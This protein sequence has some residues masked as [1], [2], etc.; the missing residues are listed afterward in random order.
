MGRP[1]MEMGFLP[2]LHRPTCI[3]NNAST[4]LPYLNELNLSFPSLALVL[5]LLT[6]EVELFE[7]L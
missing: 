6:K 1:S 3:N 5:S 2:G 7:S 4:Q